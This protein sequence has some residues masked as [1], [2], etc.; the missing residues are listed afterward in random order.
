M[1]KA[2]GV[3]V[4]HGMGTQG[5]DFADA[6]IRRVEQSLRRAGG[7]PGRVAWKPVHW[8]GLIQPREDALW[9]ALS[10]DHDLRWEGARRFVLNAFGDAIAYQRVPHHKIDTYEAIHALLRAK[11]REL[12]AELEGGPAG[13]VIMAHSLGSTIASDFI[14][15]EQKRGRTDGTPFDRLETL[16]GILTFGSNLPLF[17]L[18]FAP[19]DLKAIAFPPEA[20]PRPLR[21][22]AHW[23]NVFSPTDVLGWPLKPLNASYDESVTED[24]ELR[25]GGLLDSWNPLSHA[26]Y[27]EDEAFAALTAGLLQDLLE[28]LP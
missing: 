26:A 17:T 21:D 3:L 27:W 12:E 6:F 1:P 11:L 8:A 13:L 24:V 9:E 22:R 4:L 16:C 23:I 5:P 2:L 20:L 28:V 25:V 10:R 7:D 18:P 15:D 14:W 19:A